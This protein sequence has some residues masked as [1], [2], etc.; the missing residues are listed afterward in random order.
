M[1]ASVG[2]WAPAIDR[3]ACVGY[4]FC[5][6]PG[7]IDPVLTNFLELAGQAEYKIGV[8]ATEGGIFEGSP[9]DILESNN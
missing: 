2:A 9:L 7:F 8:L 5:C 4:G 3:R 1:H 6:F